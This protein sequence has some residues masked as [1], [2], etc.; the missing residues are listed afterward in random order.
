MGVF[1]E[2]LSFFEEIA[3]DQGTII[4]AN[5]K[6][7]IYLDAL[8]QSDLQ[9][10]RDTLNSLTK[11]C[12]EYI[13]KKPTFW[14]WSFKIP[15]EYDQGMIRGCKLTVIWHKEINNM[16]WLLLHTTHCIK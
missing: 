2:E 5:G 11:T 16:Q 12:K 10:L 6:G 8:S 1:K 9:R 7:G 14:R 4:E 13:I 3:Q 15:F